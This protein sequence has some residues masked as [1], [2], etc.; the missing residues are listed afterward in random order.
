MLIFS[1][2]NLNRAAL[3]TE[4]YELSLVSKIWLFL[5]DKLPYALSKTW[6]PILVS[7]VLLTSYIKKKCN[8]FYLSLLFI[9]LGLLSTLSMVVSPTFPTRALSGPHLFILFLA[10]SLLAIS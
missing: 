1:P 6:I 3:S 9:I 4:F 10:L 5:S 7:L 8:N 2:G